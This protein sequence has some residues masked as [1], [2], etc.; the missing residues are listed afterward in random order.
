MQLKTLHRISIK[1]SLHSQLYPVSFHYSESVPPVETSNV[2][3]KFMLIFLFA[4][5]AIASVSAALDHS[6]C[7]SERLFACSGEGDDE[8]AASLIARADVGSTKA[9]A[10]PEARLFRNVQNA[11]VSGL[12][13]EEPDSIKQDGL[14]RGRNIVKVHRNIRNGYNSALSIYDITFLGRKGLCRWLA[15]VCWLATGTGCIA[16]AFAFALRYATAVAAVRLPRQKRRPLRTPKP[17]LKI[18]IHIYVQRHVCN[19]I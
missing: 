12:S 6:P 2:T 17:R 8:Y 16:A 9:A 18:H 15:A 1:C 5:L 13:S 19:I 10:N 7:Y 11:E 14:K 3:M 4:M